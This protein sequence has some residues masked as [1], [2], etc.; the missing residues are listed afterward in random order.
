MTD[1]RT[2]GA[3][4]EQTE[5]AETSGPV[6]APNDPSDAGEAVELTDEQRAQAEADATQGDQGP[7]V[8]EQ[9]PQSTIGSD[10]NTPVAQSPPPP[11]AQ[12]GV[13][14]IPGNEGIEAPA[15]TDGPAV[16]DPASPAEGGAAPGHDAAE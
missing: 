10:P 15:Q 4:Q 3:E 7:Q 8:R 9:T 1:E 2:E 5:V 14:A 16:T 11:D 6:A 12:S 13:P